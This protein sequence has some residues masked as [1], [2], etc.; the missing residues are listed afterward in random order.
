MRKTA[1]FLFVSLCLLLALPAAAQDGVTPKFESANCMFTVPTGQKPDCGYLTVPEDRG[2]PNGRSIKLAV[3]VFHSD[4]PDKALTPLI[5]LEGGPGG[6][7]LKYLS[8][9]F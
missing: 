4:N 1:I 5:Y 2:Q 3:A 8:L 6:S 9:T 7:A